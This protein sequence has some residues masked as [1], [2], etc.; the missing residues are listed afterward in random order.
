[1]RKKTFVLVAVIFSISGCRNNNCICLDEKESR[2]AADLARKNHDFYAGVKQIV[3]DNLDS[4]DIALEKARVYKSSDKA[5]K[6][7]EE[8]KA[9]EK[10]LDEI[11]LQ[12]FRKIRSAFY[13]KENPETEREIERFSK[14]FN[15]LVKKCPGEKMD[16][17]MN[18]I[19]LKTVDFGVIGFGSPKR[20]EGD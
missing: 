17:I 4:C 9:G 12:K 5:R 14:I 16:A 2:M 10:K 7:E 13:I 11:V 1:M 18:E 19:G 20:R 6:K 15:T 8:I 3:Y